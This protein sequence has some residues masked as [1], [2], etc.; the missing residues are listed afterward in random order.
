MDS[1]WELPPIVRS[2]KNSRFVISS[3][4]CL[5]GS[6]GHNSLNPGRVTDAKGFSNF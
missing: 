4:G 3:K 5:R 6:P 2:F 1:P